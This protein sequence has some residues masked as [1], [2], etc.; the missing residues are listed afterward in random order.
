MPFPPKDERLRVRATKGSMHFGFYADDGML[1]RVL[2]TC[3]PKPRNREPNDVF[4]YPGLLYLR[5][6]YGR[7]DIGLNVGLVPQRAKDLN[8]GIEAAVGEAVLVLCLFEI[9][10][11]SYFNRMT[12]KEVDEIAEMMGMKPTW[13][14]ITYRMPSV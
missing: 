8:P 5:C 6:R 1:Q 10:E 14:H 13:W 9:E 12:Q 2:A 11:E 4:L 3:Y 7:N